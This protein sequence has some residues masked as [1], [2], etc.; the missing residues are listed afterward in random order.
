MNIFR[1]RIKI[2]Q[3]VSKI[4]KPIFADVT[5][6]HACYSIHFDVKETGKGIPD[7]IVKI[8]QH[9]AFRKHLDFYKEG[10]EMGYYYSKNPKEYYYSDE[11]VNAYK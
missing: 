3:T 4:I 11:Y 1:R 6:E 7:R 5:K 8:K 10:V 9:S 2:T